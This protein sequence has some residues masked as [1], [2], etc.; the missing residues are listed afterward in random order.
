MMTSGA[1]WDVL[2]QRGS[3]NRTFPQ[4]QHK[5][6][7]TP[8]GPRQ[9]NL[10]PYTNSL[11]VSTPDYRRCDPQRIQY[12]FPLATLNVG[13]DWRRQ[14]SSHPLSSSMLRLR[15]SPGYGSSQASG[16]RGSSSQDVHKTMDVPET[17]PPLCNPQSITMQE[18]CRSVEHVPVT[19]PGSVQSEWAIVS[20]GT[21]LFVHMPTGV[22][23]CFL[24]RYN[25]QVGSSM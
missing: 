12:Q 18:P 11:V 4:E 3:A 8:G 7:T 10:L 15:G 2:L 6:G 25:G 5:T 13:Y 24:P 14:M 22:V 23:Y 16:L 9:R 1:A 21:Q 17:A 19:Y 20:A